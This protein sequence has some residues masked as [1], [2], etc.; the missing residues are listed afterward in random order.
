MPIGGIIISVRPEKTEE[1]L[2]VLVQF[3]GVEVHGHDEQGNVVAVID[4]PST[5]VMEKIVKKINVFEAV[6]SIGFT[7]LNME[8]EVDG[9]APGERIPGLFHGVELDA[10]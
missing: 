1:I 6:L 3:P 10:G 8:D 5:W 7:Y 4:A 9:P 2:F